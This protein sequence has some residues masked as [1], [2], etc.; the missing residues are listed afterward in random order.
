ML[1]WVLIIMMT[2][3]AGESVTTMD[4]ETKALCQVVADELGIR[5][6]RSLKVWATCHLRRE[7]SKDE[8]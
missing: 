7:N 1:K 6:N 2:S 3:N 4:F 8:K 5:R